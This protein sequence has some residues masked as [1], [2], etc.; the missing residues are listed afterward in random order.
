[1]AHS[2]YPIL[3]Q[4]TASALAQQGSRISGW[5]WVVIFILVAL[6]VWWLLT[7]ATTE[8]PGIHVEH[9]EQH[10]EAHAEEVVVA[11]KAEEISVTPAPVEPAAPV[12]PPERF[13]P[14]PPAKMGEPDDLTVL[15]GIG[16]KVNGVLQAAGISTYAQLA[17]AEV[18]QIKKLLEGAGYGYMDPASW[19]Q[20]AKLLAEG[21]ME[22]FETL[23]ANLKGGRK[24]A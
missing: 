2:L 20:Q 3:A 24:V 18:E 23:T 11:H 1:M 13:A 10:E 12:S 14:L 17:A 16:P 6:L 5:V 8:D 4:A 22:E 15:E 7:R 21:R 9:G 19:P